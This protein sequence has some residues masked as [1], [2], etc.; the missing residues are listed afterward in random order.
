[1]TINSLYGEIREYSEA[2]DTEKVY[3]EFGRIFRLVVDIEPVVLEEAGYDKAD[4]VE[5]T[6]AAD[7]APADSGVWGAP[8]TRPLVMQV[9]DNFTGEEIDTRDYVNPDDIDLS[10]FDWS[11]GLYTTFPGLKYLMTIRGPLDFAMG[12][13]NGTQFTKDP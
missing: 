13:L 5:I 12:F 8:R 2:N 10:D 4:D 11:F 3:Y 7:S 9:I 6:Y 1:M